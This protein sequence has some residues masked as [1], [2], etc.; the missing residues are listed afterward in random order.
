LF[1][2]RARDWADTW[3]GSGGW[4]TSVYDH[5][6]ER[7]EI[8]PGMS[9]LDCGC[10]SGRFLATAA[11][12]GATVAGIDAAAPLIEI[13]VERTPEGD[14]RV[15]DLEALP[16]PDAAF[17]VV[18]GFS[19][20][21]FADDKRRALSEARRVARRR[22]VVVVPTRVAEAGIT[23]VFQP[24]FALFPAD[25]LEAVKNS[26]MFALSAPG[27][28]DEELAGAGLRPRADDDVESVTTFPDVDD[29][30]RAF[31]AAGPTALAISHS[32]QD[33]V[34][35]A[36]HGGLQPFTDS[37]GGVTLRGWYRVVLADA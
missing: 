32:G 37:A 33:A 1:G 14:L 22:V 4:G 17:D 3:E 7:A 2:G 26:G 8:G 11:A 18:T 20:F 30:V 10:G 15:G 36:V 34:A 23:R 6:L 25:A 5:V 9:V 19:A 12:R 24:L 13:A 27:R 28:L 29:A 31:L 35:D 16:W 21:Q